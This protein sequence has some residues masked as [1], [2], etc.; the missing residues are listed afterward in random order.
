[1][2]RYEDYWLPVKGSKEVPSL[3]EFILQ[4]PPGFSINQDE[5]IEYFKVG[6]SNFG[7]LWRNIIEGKDFKIIRDLSRVD[8]QDGFLLPID[9]WIR[10]VYR[11]AG[12]FHATPR[13][14]IK[15]LDT[16]IPL[17]YAR[18]GSLV[19]ELRDKNQEEAEQHF[20]EQARAFKI[21][22]RRRV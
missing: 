18:V 14:R 5:L 20:E 15:V 10:I 2:E 22:E 12:A 21:W 6:L 8:R 4:E 9:T 19:N 13:Q 3:G 11:Y 16:M 17:Y 7:D 1:V